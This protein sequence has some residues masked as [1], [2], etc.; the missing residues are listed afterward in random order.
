M[1]DIRLQVMRDYDGAIGYMEK[2]LQQAPYISAYMA[3]MGK[4]QEEAGNK[5]EA[6]KYY[7]K[8]IQ[9]NPFSYE[10]RKRLRKLEGQKEDVFSN[11]ESRDVY[12]IFK[13]APAASDYKDENSIV[14]LFD[15]QMVVYDGGGSEE[16]VTLVAKV[17]TA[18]GIDEWKEY[19]VP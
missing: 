6:K 19:Y 9:Y 18:A 16:R 8:T 13:N 1:S 15:R 17:F 10:E 11:F 3:K 2:V 14:L 5:D 7:Q 4:C 12:K